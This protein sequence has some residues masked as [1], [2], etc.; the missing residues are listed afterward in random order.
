MRVAIARGRRLDT[1]DL[2]A[3]QPTGILRV[4]SISAIGFSQ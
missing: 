3:S 1:P 4:K 2:T